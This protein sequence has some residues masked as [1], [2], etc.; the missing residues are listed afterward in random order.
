VTGGSGTHAPSMHTG[1]NVVQSALVVQPPG[2]V[3]RRSMQR[4]PGNGQSMS[5]PQNSAGKHRSAMQRQPPA[6]SASP[7][8]RVG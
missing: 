6:H 4:I 3:Q 2:T 5:R 7:A 8:Q 1:A